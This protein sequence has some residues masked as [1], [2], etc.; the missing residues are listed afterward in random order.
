[1]EVERPSFLQGLHRVS[2]TD[3][4]PCKTT[5]NRR[6]VFRLPR[7]F[8]KN[9]SVARFV[10]LKTNS[11]QTKPQGKSKEGG[12]SPLLGRFKG[13]CKG[14]RAPT[15]IQ[16][17]DSCGKRRNNGTDEACTP[18]AADR[19]RDVEFVPTQLPLCRPFF[20]PSTALSF[21]CGKE[22]GVEPLQRNHSVHLNERRPIHDLSG[23]F[24]HDA[25]VEGLRRYHDRA[26]DLCLGQSLVRPRARDRCRKAPEGRPRAGRAGTGRRAGAR[27]FHL[28]R[29]RGR[30]LG[31]FR[32][33]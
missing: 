11:A 18:Q 31:H 24:R 8:N 28:R 27:L 3:G 21:P 20:R 22:S 12:R 19:M 17:S 10:N 13:V 23:Q 15:R 5:R 2:R 29:H 1:M 14:A 30:Q 25:A 4:R 7:Q 6:R 16:R 9:A 33:G 32:R 26:A